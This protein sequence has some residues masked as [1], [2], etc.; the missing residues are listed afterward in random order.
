MTAASGDLLVGTSNVR[1]LRRCLAML[2]G[3]QLTLLVR[4]D[5]AAAVT[6]GIAA[7]PV[8]LYDAPTVTPAVMAATVAAQ[9]W[10]RVY[11]AFNDYQQDAYLQVLA[12][13]HA[14]DAQE[15]WGVMPNL[16][17]IPLS[18]GLRAFRRRYGMLRP[19][20][21]VL[22]YALYPLVLAY[23]V[24]ARLLGTVRPAPHF[25]TVVHQSSASAAD[26]EQH[27]TGGRASD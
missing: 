17:L 1:H 15:W 5:R 2:H 12:A 22:L 19:V 8:V 6:A 18:P 16:D 27:G 13:V 21:L 24:V 4:H 9:P 11:V 26:P 23:A 25:A 3:P 7:G 14:L 10:R 20:M